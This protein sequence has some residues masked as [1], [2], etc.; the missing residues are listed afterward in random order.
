MF[1]EDELV[2]AVDHVQHEEVAHL[3]LDAAVIFYRLYFVFELVHEE[4][5]VE[6]MEVV[7]PVAGLDHRAQE[8]KEI[9]EVESVFLVLEKIMDVDFQRFEEEEKNEKTGIF[10][11]FK[12]EKFDCD[13][14]KENIMELLLA[15]E[16]LL[17]HL[18]SVLDVLGVE[19][20]A[21]LVR[22][23]YLEVELDLH[24]FRLGGDLRL[25]DLLLREQKAVLREHF[26]HKGAEQALR[27]LESELDLR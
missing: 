5:E 20:V 14:K 4:K 26:V 27:R 13:E 15:H 10:L 9:D 24:V 16:E 21:R 25:E 23:V 12:I 2:L 6:V 22:L 17:G 8:V 3:V 18:V 7:L 11:D 19:E 1:V